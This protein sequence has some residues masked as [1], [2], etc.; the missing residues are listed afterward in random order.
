MS[1]LSLSC[2][3]V[4][5]EICGI[6]FK[7]DPDF[8]HECETEENGFPYVQVHALIGG[9]PELLEPL[10]R[11]EQLEKELSRVG[12]CGHTILKLWNY[13][14]NDNEYFLLSSKKRDIVTARVCGR[15]PS[16]RT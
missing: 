16:P 9:G 10:S 3:P 2:Y 1:S 12:A 7:V 11:E 8:V 4:G 14:T 6:H 13:E 15:T 5:C